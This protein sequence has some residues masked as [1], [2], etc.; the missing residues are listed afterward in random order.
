ME[1]GLKGRTDAPGVELSGAAVTNV[2]FSSSVSDTETGADIGGTGTSTTTANG[3]WNLI[4]IQTQPEQSRI[5]ARTK[6]RSFLLPLNM[7]SY[8]I[9]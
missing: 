4:Q 7:A 8:I 2:T 9:N 6:R 5:R 3:C 1:I